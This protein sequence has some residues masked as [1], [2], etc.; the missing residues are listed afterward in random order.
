MSLKSFNHI[1]K[2]YWYI[3]LKYASRSL[4][5]QDAEDAVSYTLTK[6]WEHSPEC[7][8]D[9][10]LR[11]WLFTT[12]K[13]RILDIK[14]RNTRRIYLDIT[15]FDFEYTQ[16]EIE[17]IEIEQEVLTYLTVLLKTLTTKEREVFDLYFLKQ[18][19]VGEISTILNRKPQ[20]IS[21]QLQ[22]IHKK[23][24]IKNGPKRIKAR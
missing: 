8:G 1:Y 16:K 19:P 6:F 21:N 22:A 12:I 11:A 10:E 23:L 13:H 14:I 15:T 18:L 4:Q 9:E 17:L 20:T 5:P 24:K 3:L 2:S 7:M